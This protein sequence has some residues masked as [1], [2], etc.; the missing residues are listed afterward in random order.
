MQSFK[1]A[2]TPIIGERV[3]HPDA[4]SIQAGTAMEGWS[5]VAKPDG[6]VR[7]VVVGTENASVCVRAREQ[8]IVA[9]SG[10]GTFIISN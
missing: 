9:I 3:I 8:V 1:V 7:L 4:T 5:T 6:T 10:S 2:H